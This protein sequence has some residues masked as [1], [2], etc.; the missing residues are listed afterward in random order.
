MLKAVG[1]FA[2]SIIN[3]G[4]TLLVGGGLDGNIEYN[5]GESLEVDSDGNWAWQLE[6]PFSGGP[7]YGPTSG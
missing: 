7:M 2:Y 6:S 1:Y 4:K 5:D 3:G